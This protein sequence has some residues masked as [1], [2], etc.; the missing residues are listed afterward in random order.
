VRDLQAGENF[1]IDTPNLAFR[2]T[3]PGDYRIDVA[4]DGSTTRVAVRSGSAQVFGEDG[5]ALRI[6]A[7][8]QAS[9]GGRTLAPVPSPRAWT[10]A[11]D[12]WA[13]DRNRLEDASLSARYLPPGVVGSV[14]LDRYGSWD[15]DP[16]FGAVWFPSGLADD[17]A[18]YR[19]GH[20]ETIQ[21]WGWTWVDDAPWGFAPFHYG[22]WT[23]IG[24]RWA[25]VP[26][27]LP[28]RPAYLPAQVRHRDAPPPR[29]LREG[30]REGTRDGAGPGHRDERFD[31][32]APRERRMPRLQG[33]LPSVEAAPPVRAW[34]RG[35]GRDDRRAL[36]PAV[37]EQLRAQHEQDR[38]QREAEREAREQIRRQ[39]QQRRAAPQFR[40]GAPDVQDVAPRVRNVA[41]QVRNVA[42]QVR[43][44]AP[45]APARVHQVAPDDDAPPR[46]AHGRWRRDD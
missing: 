25:W 44:V 4:A 23:T 21:P 13:E 1:E 2:A 5:Q 18:P 6:A 11:F 34:E 35:E 45:H 9:F 26:G 33:A 39:E 17:W 19:Y 7:G 27:R 16:E 43:N 24:G 41:P 37:R 30:T 38:L 32:D 10:D 22:R 3:E 8:E 20:W 29:Y 28:R 46:R 15:E 40:N 42:P 36:P 31:R 14:G 12:R